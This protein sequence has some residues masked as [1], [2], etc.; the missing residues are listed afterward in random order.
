MYYTSLDEV[1]KQYFMTNNLQQQLNT[2]MF[3]IITVEN[4][5]IMYIYTLEFAPCTK[6]MGL[7]ELYSKEKANIFA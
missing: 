2:K 5:H 1:S 3:K 6:S 7:L 4:V